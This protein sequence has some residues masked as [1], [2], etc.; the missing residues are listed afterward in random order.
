MLFEGD[1]GTGKTFLAKAMAREAGVPFLFVSATSFQS[2]YYGATARKIRS[3]FKELRKVARARRAERSASS[4]R[5]TPS[6]WPA[7]GLSATTMPQSLAATGLHA[8]GGLQRP[9]VGATGTPAGLVTNRSMMSEGVGGVVNELL[10]QMQSFDEPTGCR[11]C[12]PS[13][14]TG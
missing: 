9:A 2:M 7:A 8:C 13:W 6:R 1:P 11:S 12:R 4:R 14:S 5:S 3:Y 10:V